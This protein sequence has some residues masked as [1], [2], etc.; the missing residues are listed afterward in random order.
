MERRKVPSEFDFDQAY[1]AVRWQESLGF[2]FQ[3]IEIKTKDGKK[4]NEAQFELH[5]EGLV[6]PP[7]RFQPQADPIPAGHVEHWT[8]PMIVEGREQGVRLARQQ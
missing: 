1:R 2:V 7:G 8:G 6:P 5:P 3:R 4:Y